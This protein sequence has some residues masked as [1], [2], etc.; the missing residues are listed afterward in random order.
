MNYLNKIREEDGD[1]LNIDHLLSLRFKALNA[2]GIEEEYVFDPA[3][4][5][6]ETP[7]KM[8]NTHSKFNQTD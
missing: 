4:I 6:E 2:E 8:L 7:V 1:T 5:Q 3:S